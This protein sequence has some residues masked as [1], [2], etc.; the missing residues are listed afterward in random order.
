MW[1]SVPTAINP[2]WLSSEGAWRYEGVIPTD[3]EERGREYTFL[4]KGKISLDYLWLTMGLHPDKS[5]TGW[6]YYVKNAFNTP[7]LPRIMA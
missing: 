6:K 1:K 7:N 3:M 5:I 4:I 2:L